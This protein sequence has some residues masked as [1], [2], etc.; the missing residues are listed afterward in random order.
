MST[1]EIVTVF[2]TCEGWKSIS[3]ASTKPRKRVYQSS[4]DRVPE[5]E[6]RLQKR[7]DPQVVGRVRRVEQAL[8]VVDRDRRPAGVAAV[9]LVASPAVDRVLGHPEL[10]VEARPG[11]VV[12]ERR[13][14]EGDLEACRRRWQLAPALTLVSPLPAAASKMGLLL[15]AVSAATSSRRPGRLRGLARLPACV[16]SKT[17]RPPTAS[18]SRPSRGSCEPR[19]A[20]SGAPTAT[21]P[22]APSSLPKRPMPPTAARVRSIRRS[23]GAGEAAHRLRHPRDVGDELERLEGDEERQQQLEGVLGRAGDRVQAVED[24]LQRLQRRS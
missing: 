2:T 23:R 10:V 6:P 15:A 12:V 16:R 17:L 18:S 21:A 9:E 4:S 13:L 11:R 1:S 24:D 3:Q 20:T 22:A 8:G 19:P 5:C 7:L 14:G